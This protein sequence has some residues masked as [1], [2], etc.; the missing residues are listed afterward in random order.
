MDYIIEEKFE[1]GPLVTFV[2]NKK[3]PVYNWFHFKE[4]FSRDFVMMIFDQFKLREGDWVLDPFCGSGTTLLAS[5]ERGINSVGVDIM[6]LAVFLSQV[7]TMDYDLRYLK[8]V[9]QDI[10]SKRFTK[11][12]IE[13]LSPLVRRAF[14]KYALEDILFF[15]QV[16]SEIRDVLAKNFFTLA[17]MIAANKV[18]M[19]YKDGAVIKFRKRKHIPPLR[20]VFKRVV[21]KMFY[22]LKT[23]QTKK[24]I[25]KVYHADA[26][27]LDFLEDRS[28]NAVITSPPY[29]NII[30]YIKV[31]SIE[32]EL[33]FNQTKI[34]IHG[35]RSYIG[36][37]IEKN[38]SDFNYLDVPPIGKA[39]FRDMK[40]ALSEIYRL[41]NERGNA[42]LVV[43]E[44]VFPDKIIPVP[45]I[46][47]EIA[48]DIG[49][50]VK[51]IVHVNKR[52][53]TDPNRKKIGIALESLIFLEK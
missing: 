14:T 34:D 37:D 13:G 47:S 44:G 8:S 18:S 36:I 49:F 11:P 9:A 30:D 32:N 42:V 25:I 22:D 17:L 20:P 21:K 38:Y 50:Y 40:D 10:F 26:R 51:R 28:F 41:L 39:Y 53:V 24:S 15:K 1:L 29:L 27:R 33:F 23:L 35:L 45:I 5:K 43:G 12:S 3:H 19:A 6:P 7:K 4:G 52:T 16:I 31:Y 46:L 48:K 2:P